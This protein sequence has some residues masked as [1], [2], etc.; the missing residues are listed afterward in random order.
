MSNGDVTMRKLLFV[1]AAFGCTTPTSVVIEPL[2][3]INWS[4]PS[5][6]FCVGVEA[7]VWITF[8]DDL[9]PDS[10][11]ADSI[12]LRNSAGPVNTVISYDAPNFTARLAPA[13]TL[14]YDDL[15][16][17]VITEG[18]SGK[19]VGNMSVRLEASFQT[20]ARSGCTPGV[21][22]T[23]PSDCPG[24][25]ICANTGVCRSECV[26]DRDCHRAECRQGSC[27]PFDAGDS[28]PGGDATPGGD[29]NPGDTN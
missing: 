12:T 11:N 15:Y 10:L 18:V 21:E 17:V 6:A 26:T 29:T 9:E 20:V 19:E 2:R 22:C 8:S 24:T 4:P 14:L 7:N 16:T 23:M 5:G 25:Q 3:V 28:A 1:C 13:A 27:M